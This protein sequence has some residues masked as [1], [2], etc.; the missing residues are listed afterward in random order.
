VQY[1]DYSFILNTV[2][3]KAKIIRPSFRDEL[4]IT[5]INKRYLGK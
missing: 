2:V 5:S 3:E 4:E 1:R